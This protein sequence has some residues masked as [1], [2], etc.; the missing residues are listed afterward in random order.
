MQK[1]GK[2]QYKKR[3]DFFKGIKLISN[4]SLS[5]KIDISIKS[6][7]LSTSYYLKITLF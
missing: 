7:F 1:I 5:D 2:S 4:K 6:Y 3:I